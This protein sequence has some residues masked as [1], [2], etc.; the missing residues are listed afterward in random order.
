MAITILLEAVV[1][2]VVAVLVSGAPM[3]ITTGYWTM[4]SEKEV[5]LQQRSSWWSAKPKSIVYI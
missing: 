4:V 3:A 1:M 2:F 5:A